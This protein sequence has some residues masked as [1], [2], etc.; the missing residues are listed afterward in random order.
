M[1]APCVSDAEKIQPLI[2]WSLNKKNHLKV[3][4]NGIWLIWIL[5]FRWKPIAWASFTFLVCSDTLTDKR[6]RKN[7]SIRWYWWATWIPRLEMKSHLQ[8]IPS[9]MRVNLV[10]WCDSSSKAKQDRKRKE[11]LGLFKSF[12]RTFPFQSK[13][14]QSKTTQSAKASYLLSTVEEELRRRNPF[15]VPATSAK[16]R[17]LIADAPTRHRMTILKTEH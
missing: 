9:R 12:T 8:I 10:N 15:P 4:S 2:R 7:Y 6:S 16:S 11:H 14:K 5:L 13:A 17:C 1:R 3:N